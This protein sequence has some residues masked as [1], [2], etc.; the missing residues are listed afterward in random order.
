LVF[1]G[2]GYLLRR[3]VNFH[4]FWAKLSD[5][6][7]TTGKRRDCIWWSYLITAVNLLLSYFANWLLFAALGNP[8]IEF[9]FVLFAGTITNIVGLLSPLPGGIGFRELTIFGLYDFYFG[10]GGI[11]FLMIL[12][13]RVITYAA[14]LLLFL[15]EKVAFRRRNTLVTEVGFSD[16]EVKGR[17]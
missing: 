4:G 3:K 7:K 10:L 6:V 15:I 8:E 17:K 9:T 5:A 1:I 16:N 13:T 14:L 12:I 11:A 2:I